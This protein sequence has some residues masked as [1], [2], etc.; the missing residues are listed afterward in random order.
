MA[1]PPPA[2]N[3]GKVDSD[4]DR[5]SFQRGGLAARLLRSHMAVAAI[6]LAMLGV[7]LLFT[8]YRAPTQP[9]SHRSMRLWP[10][11]RGV[12]WKAWHDHSRTSA[13]GS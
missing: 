8:F 5:D 12:L 7:I 2:A 11:H 3:S 10:R 6:G 9:G 13:V 1:S 4:V